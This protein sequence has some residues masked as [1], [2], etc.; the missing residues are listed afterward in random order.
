MLGTLKESVPGRTVP[1][2][3]SC[4]GEGTASGGREPQ[5]KSH[6]SNTMK[7]HFTLTTIAKIKK[8]KDRKC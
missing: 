2:R 4:G 6:S 5:L 1:F 3:V 7:Y 8:M